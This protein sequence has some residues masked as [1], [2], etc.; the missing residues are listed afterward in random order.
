M[1]D[2]RP[3]AAGPGP[4]ARLQPIWNRHL[5]REVQYLLDLA[6]LVAAFALAYLLRFDFQVPRSQVAS[7]LVQAPLV[8]LIEFGVIVLLGIYHFV[9]RYIGMAE[10]RTFLRAG[11]YSAL[12]LVLLRLGLPESF[13]Q[14]KVP[15]SIIF[16]NGVVAF[17][18]LLGIRVLRRALHERYERSR[19]QRR[20]RE[21]RSKKVLLVGAGRAGVLAVREIRGRGDT[22]IEPVG[23]VDDDPAKLGTVIHGLKVLG[24]TA[25]LPQ[26]AQKLG[27]EQAVITIDEADAGTIRKIIRLCDRSGLRVRIIP[28]YSEILQG[29]VSISR[30]R[31]VQIEDLLGREAVRLDEDE[32]RRFLTG[33]SI[34]LTGAGGSIGSELARQVARFSP[35]RLLLVERAEAALFEIDRELRELW[36]GLGIEPLVADVGDEQRMRSIIERW[37]P[38]VVFHAAA[39]KHVPMME[40]NAVEAVKNNVLATATVGRLAGEAGV[41]AFVLVSTDKA[42]RPVSMMGATKR[43]AELV[44]QGLDAR[45]PKARFLAVRFGNVMGSAGSVV[46]IFRRQISRGGPLTVTHP[47][48][49]RYFMTIGEAAQLVLEAGAIGNGGA[50]MVLDMGEPVRIVDLAL[51]MIHLSGYKPYEEIPIEFTGL[52]PGEK[53]AEELSTSGEDIQR[54][55]HPKIF[56]GRLTAMAPEAVTAWLERLRALCSAGHDDEIRAAFDELLPEATLTRSRAPAPDAAAAG[57]GDLVH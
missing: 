8:V 30:F 13:D 12:P 29:H 36:P 37:R 41:E 34:L 56:V 1:L 18:G 32:V 54:T 16:I 19:R 24:D 47:D 52:R 48:A 45:Y 6:I 23:F 22:D 51:D 10:I 55:R 4:L 7:A 5:R 31:D 9:W 28:G 11:F 20:R 39:H 27:A 57:G 35:L 21:R 15:L 46:P 25:E 50:I 53:L 40:C 14:W 38:Q 26:L 2:E 17:G 3:T 42:V 44:V 43:C 33:R 49:S